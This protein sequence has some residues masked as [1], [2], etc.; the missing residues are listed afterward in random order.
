MEPPGATKWDYKTPAYPGAGLAVCSFLL[1]RGLVWKGDTA[2]FGNAIVFVG[3]LLV[4]INGY[5]FGG[6][7]KAPAASTDGEKSD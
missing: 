4:S 7:R 3:T 1:L 2:G 5:Y 6:Q